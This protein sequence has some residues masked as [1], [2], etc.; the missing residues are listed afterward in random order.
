MRNAGRLWI[1]FLLL[2]VIVNPAMAQQP[3]ANWEIGSLA[4]PFDLLEL[5]G[6][7]VTLESFRGKA[8]LLNFWAFWCDTW[9]KEMPQLRELAARQDDLGFRLVAISVDGTRLRE[10]ANR[11]QGNIPFPV[12]LDVGGSVTAAYQIGHVPTVLLLDGEGKVRYSSIAWPGNQ[13][14][15]NHLRKLSAAGQ[16]PVVKRTTERQKQPEQ[17]ARKKPRRH[18]NRRG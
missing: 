16:E 14:I 10:F 2:V 1:A 7:P 15:L 11:S 13:V 9:E 17:S 18:R 3:T 4:P 6:K 8:V 5:D 12:L